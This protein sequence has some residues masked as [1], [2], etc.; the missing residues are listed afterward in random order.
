MQPPEVL[1]G[2]SSFGCVLMHVGAQE[3]G[4]W[5]IEKNRFQEGERAR[6]GL[7]PALARPKIIGGR[8]VRGKKVTQ[9]RCGLKCPEEKE[10]EG[11]R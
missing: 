6:G 5:F 2:F 7:H 3:A 4:R 11:E 1:I 8:C 10:G 9:V